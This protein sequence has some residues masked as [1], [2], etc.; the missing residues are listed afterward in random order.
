MPSAAS[1][2]WIYFPKSDPAPDYLRKVCDVF[3]YH[4][5]EIDSSTK[6][7]PSNEVLEIVGN[8]LRQHG[9]KVEGDTVKV[10]VPV[11]FGKN[12]QVEKSFCADAYSFA[13]KCVL[14][15]EAGR[16]VDNNQFLKD[17]FEACMMH[18]VDYLVIAVRKIYRKRKDFDIVTT[19]FETLYA[20]CRMCIVARLTFPSALFDQAAFS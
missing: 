3:V 4:Y 13:Y 15:I 14:E 9:F 20:S 1:V 2:Q 7:L 10:S 8:S 16:A 5:A 12:G 17:L 19:F 18:D 6:S 11:L